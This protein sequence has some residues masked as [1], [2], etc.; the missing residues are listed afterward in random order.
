MIEHRFA[1][2]FSKEGS[3][4]EN[5]AKEFHGKS[6]ENVK[7]SIVCAITDNKDAKGIEKLSKFGIETTIIDPK[8]YASRN[9]FDQKVVSILQEHNVTLT[10]LAGFMRILT[11]IF[12]DNIKALNIHPSL[13]PLHKGANGM[14]ES[15]EN[16]MKIAGATVHIVSSEL[17]SGEIVEQECIKKIENE[18][19]EEFKKRV[20][21]LEYLLYPNAVRKIVLNR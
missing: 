19:F 1:I 11:P 12:T 3:N 2:L 7:T 20:H 14:R 9:A 5:L 16:S 6:F 17:D 13:L 18:S 10:L 8:E 15:Y 21:A 4:A